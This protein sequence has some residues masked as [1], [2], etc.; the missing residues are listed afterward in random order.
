MS[1]GT[2]DPAALGDKLG[3]NLLSQRA[4]MIAAMNAKGGSFDENSTIE[5]I[6]QAFAQQA[7]EG[8]ASIPE[9]ETA[10]AL[11]GVAGNIAIVKQAG[12]ETWART[13]PLP[14]DT[15]LQ[16]GEAV[17]AE[18]LTLRAAE[19]PMIPEGV[20][21]WTEHDGLRLIGV[22]M[23][24]TDELGKE[25]RISLGS[26]ADGNLNPASI[27]IG[28]Y[29][30]ADESQRDYLYAI[31][32]ATAEALSGLAVSPGWNRLV[33]KDTPSFV[34]CTAEDVG[35]MHIG[36][37]YFEGGI[38]PDQSPHPWITETL[39]SG[40]PAGLYAKINDTWGFV[41][42]S[43]AGAPG[44][45]GVSE[46]PEVETADALP[47]LSG[48]I[49]IAKQ[50]TEGAGWSPTRPLPSEFP[51]PE[52]DFA[53]PL[54][55]RAAETPKIPL[56]VD[57]WTIE[58]GMQR[59]RSFLYGTDPGTG[60][61]LMWDVMA[62]ASDSATAAMRV[63]QEID[64]PSDSTR[65]FLYIVDQY[66]A[67]GLIGLSLAPGWRELFGELGNDPTTTPCSAAD[68]GGITASSIQFD[69]GISADE[70]PHPWI[71]EESE[72]DI[73]PAGLYVNINGVWQLPPTAAAPDM[74]ALVSRVAALEAALSDAAAQVALA[75]GPELEPE[76]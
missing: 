37:I 6:F 10:D 76:P 46:I 27:S 5:D 50:A 65:T 4:A 68:V 41:G 16:D 51:T 22:N 58:D 8:G 38:R 44:V 13:L 72:G 61:R 39:Q 29:Y 62:V 42:P 71:T 14:A 67:Q 49:A 43:D 17:F 3:R 34:P 24:G 73:Q 45:G 53:E 70:S 35:T 47:G 55:L 52:G 74:G 54:T 33:L 12:S 40:S 56:I 57:H 63:V 1:N 20:D 11:P 75:N 9:V 30:E 19:T 60:S 2:P 28:F 59:L 32:P 31:D 26:H 7:M 25:A 69:N 66:A 21:Y 36:G 18:P 48:N 15:P 64:Y 23:S